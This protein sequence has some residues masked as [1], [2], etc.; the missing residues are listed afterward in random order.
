MNDDIADEIRLLKESFR[1]LKDDVPTGLLA[2]GWAVY[3]LHV[4]DDEPLEY[5]WPPTAP[6][7]YGERPELSGRSVEAARELYR[8]GGTPWTVPTRISRTDAGWLVQ[9]GEALAQRPDEPL[10]HTDDAALLSD[11]ERI[12][13]WPMSVDEALRIQQERLFAV[14]SVAA[15]DDHYQ[16][17]GLTEPYESRIAAL[18]EHQEYDAAQQHQWESAAKPSTPRPRGDIDA[19]LKLLDAAAWASKARTSLAGGAG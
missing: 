13:W 12:E 18:M 7:G 16:G 1:L 14:T 15:H 2:R 10:E 9:Y 17:F 5:F 11:L 19:R 4:D 6:A 8:A 3:D